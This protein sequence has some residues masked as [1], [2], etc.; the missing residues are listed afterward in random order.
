MC[1]RVCEFVCVCAYAYMCVCS[2]SVQVD[3]AAELAG[4]SLA[5]TAGQRESSMEV[6]P[7]ANTQHSPSELHLC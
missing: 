2:Q 4:C 3:E 5:D 7:G 1:E 6:F